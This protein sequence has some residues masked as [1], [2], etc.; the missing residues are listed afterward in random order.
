MKNATSAAR[1]MH[2]ATLVRV[3]L[4]HNPDAGGESAPDRAQIVDA[5]ESFG[6]RTRAVDRSQLD[7]VL[8]KPGDALLVAGGDGTVGKVAKRLAGTGVP[9]AVIP[10]GTANNVA[11]TLGI[12]IDPRVAID[13]L[14]RAIVRGVDLGMLD[15][16][17]GKERW[18][19]EGVGVGLFASVMAERAGKKHKKLRRAFRL[20]A[21][22]L[23]TFEPL[24]TKLD[25]DGKD[26]SGHYL[27]VSIM[28]LRSLGPALGFAPDAQFD[29]GQLDVV[30][31]RPEHRG[32]LLGY[33]RRAAAFGEAAPPRFEIHRTEY[34]R[35]DGPGSWAHVDDVSCELA[36]N[37]EARVA[38]G[39]VKFLVPPR[40][41]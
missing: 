2:P 35:L 30:L 4:I 3:T 32:E 40:P 24:R 7:D 9:M 37:T 21:D 26:L 41:S 39:A 36:R 12:G 10:T 31:I 5:L 28:N 1:L 19:L 33:L 14:P 23:E 22:E 20:L 8:K 27:L 11:R 13:G 25:V 17:C 38:P 15:L 6:W 16:K 18:F 29:D 34:A